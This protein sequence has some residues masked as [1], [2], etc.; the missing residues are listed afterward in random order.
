M[1]KGGLETM[2]EFYDELMGYLKREK[3]TTRSPEGLTDKVF[4]AI[5]KN[6]SRNLPFI[7]LAANEKQWNFYR[8]FRVITT[9]A[10]ASLIVF[11]ISE[12]WEMNQK[13]NRLET[14]LVSYQLIEDHNKY[15]SRREKIQQVLYE[16]T[17]DAATANQETNPGEAIR[18]NRRSLNYLLN[19][20]QELEK[21]NISYRTKLLQTYSDSTQFIQK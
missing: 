10:A 20:I 9:A 3:P 16:F 5:Q 13:L 1:R 8:V 15:P 18:I 21:E 14:E 7:S 11:L 17:E 2:N 19:K 6:R 12:Q 4:Q